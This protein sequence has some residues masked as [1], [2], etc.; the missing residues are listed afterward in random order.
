MAT[1]YVLSIPVSK[2]VAFDPMCEDMIRNAA[3]NYAAEIYQ[4][5]NVSVVSYRI[6]KRPLEITHAAYV[7][8][9]VEDEVAG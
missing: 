4:S 9:C 7:R 1:M 3:L 2:E 5:R 6:D 8:I